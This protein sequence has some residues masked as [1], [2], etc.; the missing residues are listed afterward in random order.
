MVLFKTLLAKYSLYAP[1]YTSYP[2]AVHFK[3]DINAMTYSQWLESIDNNTPISLY[4]HIPFCPNL[5]WYC[6]CHTKISNKYAPVEEYMQLLRREIY[7]IRDI[8]SSKKAVKEIHFGGGSPTILYPKEFKQIINTLHQCF[9]IDE[10]TEIAIELDPRHVTIDNVLSYKECG[11]TRASIGVQDFNKEVQVA[12]NRIQPFNIVYDSIKL[13]RDHGIKHISMD[14]MYGLP[15]QTT[16]MLLDNIKYTS[17]INPD[18]VALFGYAHVP[19]KKKHMQV[20][21]EST[22]PNNLERMEM[23]NAASKL[24]EENS[25]IAIGLDHFARPNDKSAKA[26]INGTLRRNFQGYIPADNDIKHPVIGLGASAISCMSSGYAQN[27]VNLKDYKEAILSGKLAT[28]K[29]IAL[30]EDDKIRGKII[31][32]IMCQMEV[33]IEAICHK[34]KISFDYFSQEISKLELMVEDNLIKIH[35]NKIHIFHN[36]RQVSRL[37]CAVFDSYINSTIQLSTYSLI[38]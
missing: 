34:Y 7:I 37:V 8:L 5:C 10:Q 24:L 29:G 17:L 4:L 25:Y 18:R 23:F 1:R 36:I 26:F 6:G 13:L 33:D 35:N 14:L 32:S 38:C 15:Y 11:V 19:W 3:P 28:F 27:Q 31:E 22:L 16:N 30:K 21:N 12:I 20:I 9:S 2:T